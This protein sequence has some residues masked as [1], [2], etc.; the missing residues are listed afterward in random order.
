MFYMYPYRILLADNT[1]FVSA[2]LCKNNSKNLILNA[3]PRDDG[4]ER[5]DPYPNGD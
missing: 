4:C 5:F 3:M 1:G 2:V